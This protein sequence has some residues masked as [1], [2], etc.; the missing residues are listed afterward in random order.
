MVMKNQF[1]SLLC[2]I[3]FL[4]SSPVFGMEDWDSVSPEKTVYQPVSRKPFTG[5][6][7]EG[8]KLPNDT[9]I[10]VA[11]HLFVKD[12]LA[13]ELVCKQWYNSL[14]PHHVSFPL[15]GDIVTGIRNIVRSQRAKITLCY[16]SQAVDSL[17]DKTDW[18]PLMPLGSVDGIFNSVEPT[19]ISYF[20]FHGQPKTFFIEGLPKV[21]RGERYGTYNTL[22]RVLE[23]TDVKF[24]LEDPRELVLGIGRSDR[25][26]LI[27]SKPKFA[28]TPEERQ[29]KKENYIKKLKERY[30]DNLL[31]FQNL[32]LSKP[33]KNYHVNDMFTLLCKE[34][35]SL[36]EI[37]TLFPP[38]MPPQDV[39][40]ILGIEQ[41]MSED[42]DVFS[43][44][45]YHTGG[46]TSE[47][48]ASSFSFSQD[49]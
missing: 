12:C 41:G 17:I 44:P 20:K 19:L 5:N 14:C 28:Q 11:Q 42:E 18:S 39:R 1:L 21:I 29:R 30:S 38:T 35:V 22:F 49:E 34:G 9:L 3:S 25:Q 2:G 4:A 32:L 36:E 31:T 23:D 33:K 16:S 6:I 15:Y 27:L 37:A 26:T 40:K 47:D 8:W 43:E 10:S 7:V 46:S 45:L 13:M 24:D 48:D